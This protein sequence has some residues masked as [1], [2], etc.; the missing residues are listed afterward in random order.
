MATVNQLSSQYHKVSHVIFDVDGLL[1]DT[2]HIYE[3]IIH[4]LLAS[5]G[6]PYPWEVR[7]KILGTSEWR[8]C[9]IAVKELDV[10]ITVNDFYK[11]YKQSCYENL[12]EAFLMKGAERIIKH[13]F[14]NNIP[15]CLA[16]SSSE[17]SVDVKTA[18]YQELFKLFHHRVC[19]SSDDDVEQG[20][21][22]PD[23][24]FVACQSF[25]GNIEPKDCLVFEDAPN[26][27]TAA[28]SAG[29]QVVMVPDSNVTEKQEANATMVIKDL[30]Q[31]NPE[32]FGL[33]PFTDEIEEEV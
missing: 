4:D 18:K 25:P 29:M 15:F 30:L 5:Y 11:Q 3:K 12:G 13:F 32:H 24:F 33:P 20:K 22:A 10:P 17:E 26:G 2:E 19:G 28:K 21:P 14:N 8:T 1:L 7:M 9:E 23:I 6:I 27:V 16:T 31:F